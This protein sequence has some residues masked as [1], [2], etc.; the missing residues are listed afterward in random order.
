MSQIQLELVAE[1]GLVSDRLA[2]RAAE[3]DQKQHP[4]S[5]DARRPTTSTIAISRTF[6]NGRVSIRS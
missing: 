1:V 4:G 5:H 3:D 2:D 6:Q